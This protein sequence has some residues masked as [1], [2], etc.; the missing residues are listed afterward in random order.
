MQIKTTQIIVLIEVQ[1]I[2]T[3]I[4]VIP[5]I[6]QVKA[7]KITFESDDRSLIVDIYSFK[8]ELGIYFLLD[9]KTINDNGMLLVC[10][11]D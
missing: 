3:L 10:F 2:I 1:Q 9:Y 11:Y 4:N 7:N 8:N 6:A 5:I